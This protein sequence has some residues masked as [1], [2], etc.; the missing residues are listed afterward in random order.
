MAVE[1]VS[2]SDF[3]SFGFKLCGKLPTQNLLRL[4]ARPPL[5][6]IISVLKIPINTWIDHETVSYSRESKFEP[7]WANKKYLRG[8]NEIIS[9]DRFSIRAPFQNKILTYVRS[10]TR[11]IM[12]R[13]FF[14][15]AIVIAAILAFSPIPIL[16][17]MLMVV[18]RGLVKTFPLIQTILGAHSTES[19]QW[20]PFSLQTTRMW[21]PIQLSLNLAWVLR[22]LQ[23]NEHVTHLSLARSLYVT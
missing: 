23:G 1:L 10:V 22:S 14:A 9:W 16:S 3:D 2:Y 5:L 19:N 21:S 6:S 7:G 13:H 8:R 15:A 11:E 12:L 20:G 17:V 18:L 4:S